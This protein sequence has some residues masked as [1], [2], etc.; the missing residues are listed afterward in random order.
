MCL[1]GPACVAEQ[2]NEARE[3][4]QETQAKH[5][6]FEKTRNHLNDASREAAA[7]IQRAKAAEAEEA[8]LATAIKNHEKTAANEEKNAARVRAVLLVFVTTV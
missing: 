1:T 8:K 2:A 4:I 6:E 5:E 3:K 7:A